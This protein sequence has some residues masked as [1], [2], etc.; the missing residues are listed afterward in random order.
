MAFRVL[1]ARGRLSLGHPADPLS[2][3]KRRR[4]S[5]RDDWGVAHRKLRHAKDRAR[6][7]K[8]RPA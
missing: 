2:R 3:R 7:C 6:H 5:R 8:R 1:G 4:A